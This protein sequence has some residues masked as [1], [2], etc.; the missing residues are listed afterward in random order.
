VTGVTHLLALVAVGAL[1]RAAEQPLGKE[2]T[3]SL[4]MRFVRIEPGVFLMGHGE[5]P[6]KSEKEWREWEYDEA[7]ALHVADV[8]TVHYA[9]DR[10]QLVGGCRYCPPTDH[11]RLDPKNSN[12]YRTARVYVSDLFNH[13][14]V[15][16]AID[17]WYFLR[18][19]R[20]K[21][22]ADLVLDYVYRWRYG[23]NDY[24]QPRGP[25]MIMVFCADAYDL[26]GDRDKWVKRASN[27][28][29][30]H[31]N[32]PLKLSFQAGIFLEGTR[33]YYEMSG[34]EAALEYIRRPCDRI[35]EAGGKPGGNTCTAMTLLYRKTGEQKYLDMAL[36]KLPQSGRFGNPWKEFGLS[37]R[38]AH[39]AIGDLHHIAQGR[40]R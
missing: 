1:A 14:K 4:G 40:G 27:V 15:A 22:V 16:G 35:I 21:D 7:H 8:H 34:D 17:R 25:G 19:H 23:D 37:M 39:I 2:F 5:R 11:V 32:R 13:H 12:D 36:Q 6:P 33:R 9:A 18:D 29:R 31:R 3:N 30:V 26:Y 38:N 24:G 20:S 10:P 28:L